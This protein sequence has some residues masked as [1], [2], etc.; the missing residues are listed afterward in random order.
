MMESMIKR[1][2][3]ARKASLSMPKLTLRK[4]NDALKAIARGLDDKRERIL[5]A[6]AR[7]LREN[8]GLG[9]ALKK[10]LML[11][12]E[13]IDGMIKAVRSLAR[14]RDPIGVTLS[15]TRLARGLELYKITVPIGVIGA[16]FE[17]RPDV[18]V[19]IS[20]LCLKSANAVILK[21]GSEAKHTNKA[22]YELIRSAADGAG[23]PAGWIQLAQTREDVKLML[24]LDE[25]VSLI[26]PRGSN[27]FVKYVMDNTRIPVLGHAAGVCHV[28]VH[29]KADVREAL[30]IV[31]DAKCQYPAVCN[32]MET[33]LVD[34]GIAR[35]FLLRM[36]D[37]LRKAGVELR[38]D[39]IVREHIPWAGKAGLKDWGTEYNDL[40]LNVRVVKGLDEAIEHI[41]RF[42][43]G[44][45]DAIVTRDEGAA[46]A[47][48]GGVDS[49]SVMWNASTRFA[50][51]FRYG[52]GSEIG[53]S[54][55]KIHARGPVGLEGLTIHKWILKGRGHTVGEYDKK[56]YEHTPMNGKWRV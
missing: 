16:I 4:R 48:M 28:F 32:A 1:A 10:R 55:N 31:Y 21:G 35:A 25:Y 53:I 37:R 12:D 2:A 26:I 23:I 42:G 5:R 13:K 43:S 27:E 24:D 40:V 44:H 56:G 29:S 30:D 52:L 15:A 33:L 54:T 36:G 18:V 11:S 20:T 9:Y 3:K 46:K 49:S 8:P 34:S 17:S 6:N 41:N 14:L 19:Q 50:D 38:G 7:D 47:F 22:L 45:T 51:G 39:E